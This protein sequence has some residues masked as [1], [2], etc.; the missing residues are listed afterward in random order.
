MGEQ[1]VITEIGGTRGFFVIKDNLL[2]IAD[3]C[4]PQSLIP[5]KIYVGHVSNVAANLNAAFVE[6]EKGKKGFLP[7][8]KKRDHIE[9]I[10]NGNTIPVQI[11]AAP[12]KTKDAVLSSEL[13]VPGLYCVVTNTPGGIH[14]SKKITTSQ[15]EVLRPLVT[16]SASPSFSY[17][18]RSN[19]MALTEKDL[20]LLS[21][22][23]KSLTDRMQEIVLKSTTRTCFSCI[24]EKSG[25]LTDSLSKTDFLQI[26][27]IVTDS[28]EEY[29]D[30]QL[31][32]PDRLSKAVRLYSD[33]KIS[34]AL[35]YEIKARL[36]QMISKKVWLK[37]GGYLIVEMTEALTV[38]DVNSGKNEKKISKA[39][40]ALETNIEAAEMIPYLL[41]VNNIS[42]IVIVDF[43]NVRSKDEEE[44]FVKHLK[45]RLSED[46]CKADVV[47]ITA[48]GLVE[49]TRQK[50]DVLLS[51]KLK[52][53]SLYEIIAH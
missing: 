44:Q 32:L 36:H 52:E 11:K 4:T 10:K 12:L 35:I 49:I 31:V 15:K 3:F 41:S 47:D 46:P 23:I 50:K 38:I 18:I 26:D 33:T 22:E 30:L 42:G 40:L 2:K 48:L 7:L 27:E 29:H 53:A 16:A 1:I 28:E 39:A 34:L 21:E 24:Y 13:S 9:G 5:G 14:F 8:D 51:A 45:K 19:V 37:S 17:I 20:P 6:Y 25:F 43:I